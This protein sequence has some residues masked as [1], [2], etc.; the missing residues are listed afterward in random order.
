[1]LD[2]SQGEGHGGVRDPRDPLPDPL[3]RLARDVDQLVAQSPLHMRVLVAEW[4]SAVDLGMG[5]I[6]AAVLVGT[7]W[8]V[9]Q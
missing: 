8:S 2:V 9:V 6:A 3:L 7:R 1:M 4:Q 5:R